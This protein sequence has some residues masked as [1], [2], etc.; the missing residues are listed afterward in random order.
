MSIDIFNMKQ[1]DT[2]ENYY[3]VRLRKV[4]KKFNFN[5]WRVVCKLSQSEG[6]PCTNKKHMRGEYGDELECECQLTH[7]IKTALQ[8]A[9]IGKRRIDHLL[10]LQASKWEERANQLT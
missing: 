5:Y 3:A 4:C 2:I 8:Y 10:P 1:G 7:G 9:N 6:T